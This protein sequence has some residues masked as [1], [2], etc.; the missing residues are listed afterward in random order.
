M[1]TQIIGLD[2]LTKVAERPSILIDA[3]HHLCPGCG[4]G[5]AVRVIGSVI[6]ELGLRGKTIVSLG[7][8]CFIQGL[9]LLDV[10]YQQ[11]LHGRAPAMASGMK[12]VLPDRLVFTLQ[13]DGDLYAEGVSEAVQAASR[14]EN[15]TIICV[16]NGV[17]G[18]TG[19]QMTPATPVGLRTKTTPNGRDAVREGK[20]LGMAELLAAV[21]GSTYVARGSVHT[22][23]E[24]Q[25][26]KR[27]LRK[28]FET[29]MSGG[30]FSYVEIL[31][32]C[33]SGWIMEPVEAM[34][35]IENELSKV[36]R[37]GEFKN[38]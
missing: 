9:R 21:P 27:Y 22:P 25:K 26:A 38:G 31:T 14:S 24:A 4:E 29:Q 11:A 36:H 17:N 35:Y 23:V 37:L 1:T 7:I 13:G 2:E 5:I 15:I 19:G 18:E 20:P 8:G 12:R 6:D 10:D 3:E 28:A 32:M 30:G 34:D 16:N 33:P